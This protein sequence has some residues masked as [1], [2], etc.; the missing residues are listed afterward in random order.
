VAFLAF[1]L[2]MTN[3]LQDIVFEFDRLWQLPLFVWWDRWIP[4]DAWVDYLHQYSNL[5]CRITKS[6]FNRAFQHSA[7]YKM[8]WSVGE[9]RN[10]VGVYLHKKYV[11]DQ[12]ISFYFV[13]K[14]K[15]EV[16]QRPSCTK[17]W[18]AF[19]ESN[20]IGRDTRKRTHE[21]SQRDAIVS[22]FLPDDNDSVIN[23]SELHNVAR[24]SAGSFWQ[25]KRI[26][27][28]FNSFDVENTLSIWIKKL[29]VAEFDHS[30]LSKLVNK[31]NEHPLENHQ[32]LYMQSKVLYLR[33]AY[34]YA[35]KDMPNDATWQQCCEH[36]INIL[37]QFGI[38]KVQ[39]F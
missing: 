16:P 14:N 26:S 29:K 23:E 5:G 33:W 1:F 35:L 27:K 32:I 38:D 2:I 7:F 11:N 24:Q 15:D 20:C 17:E 31:T 19:L 22:P 10:D 6:E 39:Y 4:D 18:A 28:L 21:Q 9:E 3:P 25:D 37:R 8:I 30:E 13:S 34:Q 12:R 36:S